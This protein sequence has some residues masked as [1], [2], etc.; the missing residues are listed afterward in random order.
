VVTRILASGGNIMA[1]KD[2]RFQV[3]AKDK[4]G[5]DGGS[6][7]LRDKQTG[8]LYLFHYAGYAG[9]LTVLLDRDGKPL[10]QVW[11]QT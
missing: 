3:I 6:E 2:Q 4:G 11:D 8:V 1:K 7:V 9:G 10:T 5:I